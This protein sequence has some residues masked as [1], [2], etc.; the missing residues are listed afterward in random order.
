MFKLFV[1]L[2]AIAN[3]SPANKPSLVI[4]LKPGFETREECIGFLKSEEGAKAKKA[5]ES[6]ADEID[7]DVAIKSVCMKAKE[8]KTE[9]DGSL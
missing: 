5:I 8:G 2:F 1:M 4:E 3:G 9:D 7:G 6:A